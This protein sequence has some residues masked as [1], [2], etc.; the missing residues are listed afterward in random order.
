[1]VIPDMNFRPLKREAY[2]NF[3]GPD[4]WENDRQTTWYVNG[5]QMETSSMTPPYPPKGI[6]T[7][8]VFVGIESRHGRYRILPMSLQ[9]LWR[10][11]LL[12]GPEL[13][14]L[15][16]A[17]EGNLTISDY[18]PPFM[19]FCLRMLSFAFAA[20]L[21]VP[22]TA[23][24]VWTKDFSDVLPYAVIFCIVLTLLPTGILIRQRIR[25]RRLTSRYR[26]LIADQGI[27]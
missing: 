18:P 22:T 26:T 9:S 11:G 15:L 6:A 16:Y 3:T 14:A 19:D 20:I 8:A 13:P 24:L 2:L 5:Y 17:T 23:L 7:Q 10:E 1:M 12:L 27:E 4:P 25:L 21:V